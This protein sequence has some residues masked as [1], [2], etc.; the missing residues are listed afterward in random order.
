MPILLTAAMKGQSRASPTRPGCGTAAPEGL[1]R[2]PP[3]TKGPQLCRE[4]TASS[5]GKHRAASPLTR[6]HFKVVPLISFSSSP[7]GI[8][9]IGTSAPGYILT[10]PKC[11]ERPLSPHAEVSVTCFDPVSHSCDRATG[12]NPCSP[13]LYSNYQH[14]HLYLDGVLQLQVYLD[15][16]MTAFQQLQQ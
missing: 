8:Q 15:S 14:L 11:Q 9:Q 13:A 10:A 7:S 1:Q 16:R 3:T 5:V 12:Q 2:P 6:L 4:V